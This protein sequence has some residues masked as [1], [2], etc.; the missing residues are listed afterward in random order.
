MRDPRRHLHVILRI[1]RPPV[2]ACDLRQPLNLFTATAAG[3]ATRIARGIPLS[4]ATPSHR[5]TEPR[6]DRI[7]L[8]TSPHRSRPPAP[9]APPNR[10]HRTF[11]RTDPAA[12]RT[13]IPASSV[14]TLAGIPTIAPGP[15]QAIVFNP[16][17]P[18]PVWSTF[19]PA[20]VVQFSTSL[21]RFGQL[22]RRREP[23]LL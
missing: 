22:S 16:A 11:L 20:W 8:R 15:V 3:E 17:L 5:L 13:M 9:A 1:N 10:H 7:R 19:Q 12:L 4:P 21:D 23:V 14:A 2:L 18:T 6:N